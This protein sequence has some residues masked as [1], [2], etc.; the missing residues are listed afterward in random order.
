MKHKRTTLTVLAAAAVLTT[1]GAAW[2]TTLD[3]PADSAPPSTA[4]GMC[5]PATDTDEDKAGYAQTIA[6]VT[7]DRTAEYREEGEAPGG[8]LLSKVTVVEP[9]KGTPPATM[10]IGQSVLRQAGG[11]Y[12][13]TKP[14]YL[15]LEPGHRYI[16][17]TVPDPAYGDGW[18]WFATDADN[19]LTA[20][21]A[22]WTRAIDHQIAPHPDPACD[23]VAT[24]ASSPAAR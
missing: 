14:A 22:R 4:H 8:A 6:L 13:K 17:G 7:V 11:G 15:P 20:A 1:A 2:Y 18:V 12:A 24:D 10:T 5:L 19:D 9:F 3:T 23:D 21:T 16:V